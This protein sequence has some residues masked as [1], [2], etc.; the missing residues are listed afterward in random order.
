MNVGMHDRLFKGDCNLL[1]A[2]W[3]QAAVHS[4]S[5]MELQCLRLAMPLTESGLTV[6]FLS[7]QGCDQHRFTGVHKGYYIST[8]CPAAM[9]VNA[10]EHSLP[11]ASGADEI[12]FEDVFSCRRSGNMGIAP[13]SQNPFERARV[14]L[15]RRKEAK[16][17]MEPGSVRRTHDETLSAAIARA[18]I[19]L[20]FQAQSARRPLLTLTRCSIR[21]H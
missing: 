19:A 6:G 2:E 4:D 20:P 13:N 15:K 21:A 5:I 10:L 8:Y 16:L 7:S 1:P 11:A 3:S 12:S 9:Y 14:F 17:S 18:W